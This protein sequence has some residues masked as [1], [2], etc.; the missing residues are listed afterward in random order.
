MTQEQ[1]KQIILKAVNRLIDSDPNFAEN[2]SKLADLSEKN[3]FIYN[4]A[5]K[6]LKSL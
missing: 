5:V 4:E 1:Q 6:K 2:I 3:K